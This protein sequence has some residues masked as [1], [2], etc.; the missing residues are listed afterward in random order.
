M[1]KE[2]N[3]ETRGWDILG[4]NMG[5]VT[6]N[7]EPALDI[8]QQQRR[9][10]SLCGRGQVSYPRSF[11]RP[12]TV[13]QL[14][15]RRHRVPLSSGPLLMWGQ[16]RPLPAQ[17][18]LGDSLHPRGD[19]ECRERRQAVLALQNEG[20]SSEDP[21]HHTHPACGTGA[22]AQG[23]GGCDRLA[24]GMEPC[25]W[26]WPTAHAVDMRSVPTH[27]S[28]DTQG[29]LLPHRLHEV[30]IHSRKFRCFTC[31]EGMVGLVLQQGMGSQTRGGSGARVALSC[32]PFSATLGVPGACSCHP[33]VQN[34][35][36]RDRQ[37]P[38]R[39]PQ[40][41]QPQQEWR[42]GPV[43]EGPYIRATNAYDEPTPSLPQK[44]LSH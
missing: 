40:L 7:P 35:S 3:A 8:F 19:W 34:A 41:L 25:A 15:E 1:N 33:G 20:S 37:H 26:R 38:S 31:T 23:Q 21:C 27:G 32:T 10:P 14:T 22:S 5:L 2:A 39:V 12:L 9:P 28:L 18:L 17:G 13:A 42:R 44:D 36:V 30:K 16:V 43:E 24:G 4:R 29:G 6:L 11:H